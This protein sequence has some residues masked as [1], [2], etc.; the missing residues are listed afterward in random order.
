MNQLLKQFLQEARENLNF[1]DQNLER[2]ETANDELINAI[3]RAAHTLKGDSGIVGFLAIQEITHNA[4]DLLDQYRDKKIEFR[5]EMI[6]A[7]YNAFDEVMNLVEAAE[8]QGDIVQA[9]EEK[10]KNIIKSLKII[11]N[12]GDELIEVED[13]FS[14]PYREVSKEQK[15]ILLKS[16]FS[17]LIESG[18]TIPL[19]ISIN[20][21]DDLKKKYLY[22]IIFDIDADCM[23]FGNDP[24][25][26]LSLMNNDVLNIST[27]ITKE[28]A[29]KNIDSDDSDDGLKLNISLSVFVYATYD[30][31]QNAL[32]N[33]LDDCLFLPLDINTLL[34]VDSGNDNEL[35]VID[36]IVQNGK[37]LLK[38]NKKT[39]FVQLIQSSL[40]LIGNE[41]NH[42]LV[43]QRLMDIIMISD[44]DGTNACI[45][46]LAKLQN[47]LSKSN[48][49]EDIENKETLIYEKKEKT[50]KIDI[51]L[52]EEIIIDILEQQLVQLEVVSSAGVLERVHSI[53]EKLEPYLSHSLEEHL[54]TKDDYKEWIEKQLNSYKTKKATK[55]K[56]SKFVVK[57]NERKIKPIEKQTRG[58][59]VGKTVK[60]EQESIDYLMNLIGEL[61]VAKN[62]LPYL[63]DNSINMDAK[64]IK[65][66]I[67]EKYTNINRL[68]D[69]LQDIIMSMRMLPVSY[70]FDRYPKLIRDISKKLNKKVK[71]V[72]SG[73]ETK[74]DKNI[75]EMLADPLIHIIRN[76]LDHGIESKEDRIKLGKTEEGYINLNAYAQSDKIVIEI[77]DDGAGINVERVVKKVLEKGLLDAEDI[78]KMSY[79]E[80]AELIFLVGLSTNETITEF[81][82]RGVGMDVVKKSLDTFNGQINLQT[83]KNKG[84]KILLTIPASLAVTSLLHILMNQTHYGIPMDSVSETVKIKKDDITYLHNE[85]FVYINKDIVPVLFIDQML[86]QDELDYDNI[87]VV[88]LNI[89]GNLLAVV[90]NELLGQLEV[91]QKP[92]EGILEKHP[93]LSG[94]ALLGN[95]QIIM[96]LDPLGLLGSIE[97]IKTKEDQSVA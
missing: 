56:A 83:K 87:A 15:E 54:S 89:K 27:C 92:L 67:L 13:I 8:I 26:A 97:S 55:E 38:T 12:D 23:I 51:N 64:N 18:I 85:P 94:T 22:A 53:V 28:M 17:F 60:I 11:I 68:T 93:L 86:N 91:V 84:T 35:G 41:S 1:I 66:A 40:G 20:T 74:L 21:E 73:G 47:N 71:L 9:D 49:I 45:S 16:D 79:N 42:S 34:K 6:D 61:L 30:T 50:I 76:S 31:I 90:V 19:D 69:E 59:I 95:G 70:V 58:S 52:K 3:F 57:K 82:G 48:H 2:L 65:R 46:S 39:E 80:Q 36:D 25:Y 81:S 14:L 29:H 77:V 10:V 72:V 62:S 63:A 7:L 44:E 33:F 96:S 88:V 37:N 78:D 4:E 75:I 32:Y 5:P 43:L 24:I